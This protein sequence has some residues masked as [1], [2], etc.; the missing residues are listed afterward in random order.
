MKNAFFSVTDVDKSGREVFSCSSSQLEG[1]V[2]EL[3]VGFNTPGVLQE[4]D[5]LELRKLESTADCIK[6]SVDH[7][8][9]HTTSCSK[10]TRVDLT[11][12]LAFSFR[13]RLDFLS[14]EEHGGFV[15][16]NA[17]ES[18][19]ISAISDVHRFI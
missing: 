14:F 1:P 7:I 17:H 3:Q 11:G 13:G 5:R 9:S 15:Q 2:G 8:I 12:K 4:I 19:F 18:F 10:C 6:V 16:E